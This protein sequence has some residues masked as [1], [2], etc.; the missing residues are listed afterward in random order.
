M[1]KPS[2]QNVALRELLKSHGV[3]YEALASLVRVVAAE[4]GEHLRTNRSGIA[5][6]VAG[7][8]PA[9]ATMLYAAEALSRRLGR[10]VAL[11]EIGFA[12]GPARS[13]N[14]WPED[15]LAALTDLGRLDLDINRRRALSGAAYS[16]AA[17]AL[18]THSWWSQKA[19]YAEATQGPK[20][21][22]VGKRDLVAVQDMARAFS[23][24]DQRHGGGHARTSVVQYLS[25]DVVRYLS[26]HFVDSAVRRGMY[27]SASELA[28]VSGWMAF[29]NAE[30]A[31]AQK[32]FTLAVSLAAEADNAPMAGHVLRAMAHQAVDLGHPQQAL[33]LAEASIEGARLSEASSRERSLMGVVHARALA[34]SG[35]RQ[36]AAAALLRAEDDLAAATPGDDEPSRVF[37]FGEASLAH[38]TACVL[39][40]SGDPAGAQREFQRS[41]RTRKASS[42]TRTHAVTLGYLGSVQARQGA[43]EE[44]CATWARALDSMDGIHSAR[45]RRTAH[46]MRRALSPMRGRGIPAVVELD[47]RAGNYLRESA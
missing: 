8:Q 37:F 16:L 23:A 15:T 33:V 36:A 27:T 4:A 11:S 43:I 47:R 26:G 28:Y 13:E 40:D 22:I 17:L 19:G 29:D 44:A 21:R 32:Y 1:G 34:A 39:R 25:T 12:V 3:T 9:E 30:H 35:Q 41:V 10:S 18:P 24:I 42:F 46:D 7:V 6:W 45:A 5:H 31:V 14:V 38:E 2:R 20:R